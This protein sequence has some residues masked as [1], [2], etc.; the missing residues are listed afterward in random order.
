MALYKDYA[1]VTYSTFAAFDP[2][3]DSG[4]PAPHAGIYRCTKCGYE[5]GIAFG[6]ILPPEGH[7]QHPA[8]LGPIRWQLL[9]F[10][11]HNQ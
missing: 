11:Q 1:N 6:H 4:T 9:V 8:S 10:A 5:I 7:H 3:Y 2:S